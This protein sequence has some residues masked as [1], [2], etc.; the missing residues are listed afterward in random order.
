MSSMY[1]IFANI[2]HKNQPN[3]GK[4]TIHGW[5]GKG[6]KTSPST[7]KHLIPLPETNRKKTWQISRAPQGKDRLPT[8]NFRVLCLFQGE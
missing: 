8:I 4:Y 6:S 1:G 5:Y 2:Y 7:K 3:A